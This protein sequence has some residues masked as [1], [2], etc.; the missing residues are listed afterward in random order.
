MA[1]FLPSLIVFL[2]SVCQIEALSTEYCI[3][4]QDSEAYD[5]RILYSECQAFFSVVRIGP[6]T[7]PSRK[8][9]LFL[10]PW[11]QGGKHIR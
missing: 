4:Y 8:G 2:L 5:H 11:I 7:H 10:P 9:I 1:T 3:G 6:H